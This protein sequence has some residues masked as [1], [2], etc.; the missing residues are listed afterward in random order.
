VA[1]FFADGVVFLNFAQE[2]HESI[3]YFAADLRR[4]GRSDAISGL[5]ALSALIRGKN[6]PRFD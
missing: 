1:A 4:I 3:K 2:K 5:S 6:T